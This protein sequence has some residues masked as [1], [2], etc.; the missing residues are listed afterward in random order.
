MHHRKILAAVCA[1]CAAAIAALTPGQRVFSQIPG[2]DTTQVIMVWGDTTRVGAAG[3][4][5]AA[6]APVIVDGIVATVEDRAIFK[7]EVD[8]EIKNLMIQTQ[9]T[10]LPPDEEKTLRQEALQSLIATALLSIQADRDN[11]RVEEKEL[12]AAVERWIAQK[13][14]EIGGDDAFA[15]QLAAEGL[16][17]DTLRE[18]YRENI[19]TLLLIDKIKYQK[20]MPDVQVTEAEVRAYYKAHL[21]EFP[22]KE[23]TVSI[24]HILI[25]PKPSEAVLAKALEK[26][27]MIEGKLKAGE[28]FAAT[29]KAYSDCPSAKFG[30]NLGTLNLDELNNPPFADAARKVAVG[31]VSGPVLTEFGYHIIKI[32]GVEGDQ[33]TLRHILVRAEPGAEDVEA[34][35]KIAERVREELGGGADFAQEA[36]KYSGDYGT[37][38]KGGVFGEVEIKNLPDKF[39]EGIKGVPAGGLAPVMKEERGF[40]IVKVLGWNEA[41]TYTYDEAKNQVRRVLTEQKIM[42]KMSAYVEE[43]KKSYAIAI[44]GE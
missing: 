23:P 30:G 40:R 3:A 4:G 27:T 25:V 9:R 17:M 8:N 7:S 43:L 24:A 39:K 14:T 20:I 44:K 31:Q 6:S 12:D 15:R 1:I 5:T 38:D 16:T 19:R 18:R 22:Q 36:A 42:E 21:S 35:A 32:E 28:D 33:V 37:K 29:A 26:I 34:A 10:S 2:A 41:G 11:L 13:K